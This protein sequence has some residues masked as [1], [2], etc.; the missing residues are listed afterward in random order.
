[1]SGRSNTNPIP[2]RAIAIVFVHFLLSLIAVY[3][4]GFCWGGF[5]RDRFRRDS[6]A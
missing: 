5:L 3:F 4:H 6:K 1:M 2:N